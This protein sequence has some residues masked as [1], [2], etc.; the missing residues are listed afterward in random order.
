VSITDED[1]L[2]ILERKLALAETEFQAANLD[3]RMDELKQMRIQ[4][5]RTAREQLFLRSAQL[6]GLAAN[7]H[8]TR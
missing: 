1:Q 7:K 6:R 4:Q 5:V 8:V 3:Q 2:N